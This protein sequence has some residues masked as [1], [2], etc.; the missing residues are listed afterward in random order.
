MDGPVVT[1]GPTGRLRRDSS[2]ALIVLAVA[3]GAGS[4]YVHAA[5]VAGMDTL[6]APRTIR[7]LEFTTPVRMDGRLDEPFWSTADSID[8][9]FQHE[10]SAGDPATQRTIVKVVRND[11][12]LYVGVR[13]CDRDAAHLRST[14]LRRDA[15][16][17]ADDNVG[18]LIDCLHRSR[19]ALLF[20]TNPRGAMRDVAFS[21]PENLDDSWNGIWE[22]AT[23]RDSAGWTAEFRIPFRTLRYPRGADPIFGLN[24]RRFDPRRNEEDLWRSF[25]RTQGFYQLQ[26][27]GALSGFHGVSRGHDVELLPYALTEQTERAYGLNGA[28]VNAASLDARVGLDVKVAATP[29]LTGDVT[30]HTDFSQVEADEPRINLTRFPLLYPEKREFFIESNDL[31]AFGGL[32]TS[33]ADDLSNALLFYSRRIGIEDGR[34]IPI[35]AAGRL[36]GRLGPWSVGLLDARTGGPEAANDVVVRLKRD[37]LERASVGTIATVRTQTGLASA[38]SA[39]GVDLDFPLVVAGQNLEPALWVAA[40]ENPGTQV[41]AVGWRGYIDYPNDLWDNFAS[42]SRID[43]GFDPPLGFVTRTGILRT[44]GHLDFMPRPRALGIRQLDIVP[45]SW[46]VYADEHGSLARIDDWQTALLAWHP[47]GGTMNSG[48]RFAGSMERR[49]DAPRDTFDAFRN[50]HIPPGQYWWTRGRIVYETSSSRPLSGSLDASAGE[51]YEGHSDDLTLGGTWR[52]GGHLI[53]SGSFTRS[54]V[55]LP[56]G[57][58][59]ASVASTRVECA[60]STRSDVLLLAQHDNT[61]QRFDVDLRFH[62]SPVIGDDLYLVRTSGYSTDP[63]A[64]YQVPHQD[65]WARPLNGGIVAKIVHRIGV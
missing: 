22:V 58:F 8:D 27:A 28:P 24:V 41:P 35:L 12:A 43:P 17:D 6:P 65:A 36:Y 52:G 25:G 46:D 26:N 44:A 2:F 48:D 51:F 11:R 9:F 56:R 57:N 1:R 13:A 14:Q 10:P 3:L 20:Q 53:L 42:I 62:W 33:A 40:T 64:R 50:V 63:A 18:L 16:L 47:F 38:R 30:V 4:R 19:E 61:D 39:G 49:F 23:R 34:P 29:T 31:F 7:V 37:V 15:D 5:P 21:V 45:L 60:F 32:I 59:L 54:L 55:R